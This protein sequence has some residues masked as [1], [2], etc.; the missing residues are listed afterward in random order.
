LTATQILDSFLC[1]MARPATLAGNAP[2]AQ[3]GGS[4]ISKASLEQK[5]ERL[6]T[7][8]SQASSEQL[9]EYIFRFDMSWIHHDSALEGVVY[10]P[11]ELVAAVSDNV[12]SDNSLVP[13]YDEIRQ[14]KA[15]IDF[16]RKH[17]ADKNEPITLESIKQIYLI[18]APEEAEGRNAPRYRKDM[19]LHRVY[20]HDIAKPEKISGQL[21]QLVS[22]LNSPEP[23][24]TMHPV[25][26]ASKAHYEIL[27]T[28]PF[29]K[30]TGKLARLF[31]N[32]ILL[33]EGYPPTVI[34]ATDRQRYYEAMKTS[35]DAVAA[36]V[37]ES[38]RNTVNAALSYFS[39][40][41][42]KD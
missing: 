4:G 10:D 17:A 13:T 2:T 6:R 27:H 35:P 42:A 7:L 5:L 21:R 9:A 12:V 19:P 16:V 41:P 14:H 30:H 22:W 8:Q 37:Q 1:E 18:L 29:P 36:I 20:F 32:L 38:L 11:S 25:R 15:A 3:R 34:H 40:S 26:I 24:R 39:S 33:R 28:S 31:M 23:R